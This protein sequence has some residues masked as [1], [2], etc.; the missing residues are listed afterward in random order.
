MRASI[1]FLLF[2]IGLATTACGAPI[3]RS[4][5][6]L[7][8]PA[9][10][11][12][13]EVEPYVARWA[14]TPPDQTRAERADV[15]S[16]IDGLWAINIGW[17]TTTDDGQTIYVI[18]IPLEVFGDWTRGYYYIY[19]GRELEETSQLRLRR[20]DEHWYIYNRNE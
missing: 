15:A 9:P 4:E 16:H 10:D 14:T 18:D 17:N 1:L 8:A 13:R 3:F 5:E 2:L 11:V 12:V 7:F 6:E 19:D 20:V